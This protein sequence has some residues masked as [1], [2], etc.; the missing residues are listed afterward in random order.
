MRRLHRFNSAAAL[1]LLIL[2]LIHLTSGLFEFGIGCPQIRSMLE[3]ILSTNRLRVFDFLPLD[4]RYHLLVQVWD[5]FHIWFFVCWS[6]YAFHS[7]HIGVR[8]PTCST[9]FSSCKYRFF[10]F[11]NQMK[12][13][14]IT[15]S[16][17]ERSSFVRRAFRLKM[18]T[19]V[20]FIFPSMSCSRAVVL[21]YDKVSWSCQNAMFSSSSSFIW[22]QP[23]K[24]S[25]A[26]LL[27][28]CAN[29]TLSRPF[30]Y[31][32]QNLSMQTWWKW[33]APHWPFLFP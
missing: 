4:C 31:L 16:L 25:G 21:W 29:F 32:L 23:S 8:L 19:R 7:L 2:L 10:F 18:G 28:I 14:W 22:I 6:F 11:F 26:V 15:G 27:S 12:R 30:G 3:S 20:K 17:L 5:Y 9:L 24:V 33:I 1:L 13:H